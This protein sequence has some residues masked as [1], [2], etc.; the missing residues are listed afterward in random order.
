MAEEIPDNVDSAIFFEIVQKT[1]GES[2]F[3]RIVNSALLG[4]G[5]QS[6]KGVY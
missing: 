3:Y 5:V 6:Q 2:A 4:V 1:S